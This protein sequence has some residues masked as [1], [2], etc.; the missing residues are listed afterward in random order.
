MQ[1][2]LS[3]EAR[4]RIE[5]RAI[6]SLKP[7]PGN[8]RKHPKSQIRKIAKSQRQ[9]GWTNPILIDAEGTVLC[10]HGRLEAAQLNGDREVP[11]ISLEHL[12]EA[13]RK[14]YIIADNRIAEEAQWSKAAL[15]RELSGLAELGYELEMTGFDNLE[16]DTILSM[17][18]DP[19]EEDQVELPEE[20]ARP[21]SRLGDLWEVGPH[22]LLVG[23]ARD[24]AAY[25]A[26]L[27]GERAEL[28]VTDPPYGCVIENNVSGGGKKKH[29]NF[30]MG[31][32][33][34]SLPE[35][36]ANLLHPTFQRIAENAAPGAIA[37]VFIDWRGAPYLHQAAEGVFQE[38]KNLIVWAK[39][40][41]GQG[42]FYRSAHELIYAFKVNAGKHINNFGLSGR[43]RTNVWGYPGANT[44]RPGR[45]EDLADHPTVKPKKMIADAILDCS[46]HGGV[47][48]DPFLGA[49]TT[50]C[51]AEAVGRIGRG[52]ELDPIYVDVS[53]RRLAKACK[54]TPMLDGRSFDEVAH[55]RL[56]TESNNG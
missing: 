41:G 44:F 43:Y 10:G 26:L 50:L 20:N 8:A 42:A 11:V 16:I 53:V 45:M 23:D 40:N 30:V 9:F 3:N 32:G 14:A 17:D 29:G 56:S 33:E 15:H 19:I 36:A 6:G 54:A 1:S 52:I 48:L 46:K 24:P 28:I 27:Q 55:E 37:F 22:R 35:F 18:D 5:Y 2:A 25:E 13:D 49:G 47:V 7:Y 34:T 21:V 38:T 4:L 31:A 12:G 51:A 39:T